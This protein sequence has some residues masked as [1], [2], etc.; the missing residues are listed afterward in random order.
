MKLDYGATADSGGVTYVEFDVPANCL[1]TSLLR[2]Q[3]YSPV[4]AK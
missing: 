3:I 4:R 2:T 1:Y